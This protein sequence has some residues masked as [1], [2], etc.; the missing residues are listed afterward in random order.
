MSLRHDDFIL[1]SNRTVWLNNYFAFI[2]ASQ[3]TF[4]AH[5]NKLRNLI[6]VA[7]VDDWKSV[8][9]NQNFVT[10]AVNSNRVV[11]V[12]VCGH[13]IGTVRCWCELNVD[14][15]CDT[16]WNHSLFRV[17]DLEVLSLRRQNMQPLWC[18]TYVYQTDLQSVCFVHFEPAE[19]HNCGRGLEDSVRA[20]G[21]KSIF[22]SDW[23]GLACLSFCKQI[24]LDL[25]SVMRF[26]NRMLL[27]VN[28]WLLWQSRRSS[29]LPP[30]IA[31][32]LVVGAHLAVSLIRSK[33]QSRRIRFTGLMCFS[34]LWVRNSLGSC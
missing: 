7:A 2:S 27:N 5:I 33:R 23:V 20:H 28:A 8:N 9:W 32:C 12:F 16:S 29:V 1:K 30:L 18:W 10:F 14:V 34:Q 22:L 6:R 3:S 31:L 4:L 13:A 17:P 21:V 25:N 11:V 24:L 19:F 15:F 26:W